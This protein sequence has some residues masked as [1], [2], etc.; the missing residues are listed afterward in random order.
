MDPD[1]RLIAPDSENGRIQTY[2]Q[3]GT[4]MLQW[5]SEGSADGQ[6][7]HPTAVATDAAGIVYVLDKDNHRIQKFGS[8][9]TSTRASTWGGLKRLYR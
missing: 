5:G 6:F 1:G 2:R 3:D 4:F 8:V 7:F 9:A